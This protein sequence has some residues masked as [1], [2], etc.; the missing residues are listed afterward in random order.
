VETK[1]WLI[2]EHSKRRM[3]LNFH[4]KGNE[5]VTFLLAGVLFHIITP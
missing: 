2:L 4:I 1:L 5:N 3:S